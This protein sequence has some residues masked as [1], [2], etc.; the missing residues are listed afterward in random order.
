[1]LLQ[2]HRPQG[3]EGYIDPEK[4]NVRPPKDTNKHPVTNPKEMKVS[5]LTKSSK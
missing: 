4:A 3:K 5:H 1:M 2:L